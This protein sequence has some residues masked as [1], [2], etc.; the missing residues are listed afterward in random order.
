M[1]LILIIFIISISN[2][3]GQDYSEINK[4]LDLT[5][6]LEYEN[7]I[8]IYKDF[9]ITDGMQIF[10]MYNK[11]KNEWVVN[12]YYY[13]K[14]FKS[15]TKIDMIEFPKEN[16]GKLKAKNANLIWLKFLL[17]DID[18]LPNLK[19]ISYKLKKSKIEFIDG[20][21]AI[22]RNVISVVD[23]QSY[24]VNFRNFKITN[25]FIFNNPETYL[26]NY[27]DVDELISYNQIV[28]IIKNEFNL[29][30]D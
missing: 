2:C 9:S 28:T 14:T 15:A 1:K 3:F 23:G 20:E 17:T 10:R 29:W 26:S 11:G 27:S 6:S 18:K 4:S 22:A 12:I 16:L 5:D 19:D 8:R 7:E 13:N 30:N 21:Y 25:N 24:F